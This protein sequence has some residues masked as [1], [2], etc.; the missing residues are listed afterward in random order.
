MTTFCLS[1]PQLTNIWV[2]ST[3]GLL[4][5]TLLRTSTYKFWCGYRFS[6]LID[7]FLGVELLDCTVTRLSVSDLCVLSDESYCLFVCF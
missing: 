4:S 3:L 6:P 7:I 1:S 5:V 2:I